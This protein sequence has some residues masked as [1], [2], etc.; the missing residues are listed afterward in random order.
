MIRSAENSTVLEPSSGTACQLRAASVAVAS[1]ISIRVSGLSTCGHHSKR[2]EQPHSYLDATIQFMIGRQQK[3]AKSV[4]CAS[5]DHY[6]LV[7]LQAGTT[8]MPYLQVDSIYVQLSGCHRDEK[9][10]V[11]LLKAASVVVLRAEPIDHDHHHHHH[12]HIS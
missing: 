2:S 12:H 7:A 5:T 8:R 1:T 11:E 4:A 9:S 10:H 3:A 6:L